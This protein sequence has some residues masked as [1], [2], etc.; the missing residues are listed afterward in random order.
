MDGYDKRMRVCRLC[1][2]K[3]RSAAGPYSAKPG[4]GALAP[5]SG[6]RAHERLPTV[7]LCVAERSE[8][9]AEGGLAPYYPPPVECS[10]SAS[11]AVDSA[12]DFAEDSLAD[13]QAMNL[14][15]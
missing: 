15:F 13:V 12:E 2:P 3:V 11:E 14:S 10:A 8:H 5:H 1:T 9:A 6:W 7:P 4:S